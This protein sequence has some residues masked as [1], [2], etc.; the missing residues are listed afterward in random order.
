MVKIKQCASAKHFQ[1]ISLNL[2]GGMPDDRIRIEVILTD[3]N[4]DGL[5]R[6]DITV[7]I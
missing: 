6:Q 2:S 7:S 3:D 4:D 1:T 5:S